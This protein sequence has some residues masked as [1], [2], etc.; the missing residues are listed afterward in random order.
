VIKGELKR[1][2]SL[3][4]DFLEIAQPAPLRLGDHDIDEIIQGVVVLL[5][6][7]AEV[8]GVELVAE[9]SS[10][11]TRAFVDPSRFRQVLINL[12]RNA[13]EAVVGTGR[14]LVRSQRAKDWIEVSVTDSGPGIPPEERTKVFRRFYR[15]ERNRTSTA[16]ASGSPKRQLYSMTRGAPAASIMSPAYRKPV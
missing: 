2:S 14:V 6:P 5:G 9:R 16:C 13:I 4:T 10:R 7:E 1:L 15:L 3:M 11:A 12:L 8:R